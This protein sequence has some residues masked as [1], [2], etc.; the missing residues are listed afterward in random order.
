VGW[1]LFIAFFY[2]AGMKAV[3]VFDMVDQVFDAGEALIVRK[4]DR[5][6]RV[7]LA[8][9]IDVYHYHSNRTPCVTL[10]LR[11]PSQFGDQFSFCTGPLEPFFGPSAVITELIRRIWAARLSNAR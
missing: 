4:G 2:Y 7:L 9:I 6:E 1:P 10:K 11:T 5:V 8:D 3:G